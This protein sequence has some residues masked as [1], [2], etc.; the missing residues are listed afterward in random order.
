MVMREVI[1]QKMSMRWPEALNF[2]SIRSS[3]SNL[4]EARYNSGLRNRNNYM[5]MYNTNIYCYTIL[6]RKNLTHTYM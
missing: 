2:G 1:W 5:Y 6:A 4:P 3:T